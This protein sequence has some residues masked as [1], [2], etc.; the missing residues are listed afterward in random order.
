MW[1]LYFYGEIATPE[2][3]SLSRLANCVRTIGIPDDLEWFETADIAWQAVNAGLIARQFAGHR[4][5]PPLKL[6][7]G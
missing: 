4:E 6:V 1:R 3:D 2:T 7:H 5:L